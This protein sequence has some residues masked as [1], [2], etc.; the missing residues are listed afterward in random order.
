MRISFAAG[1]RQDI[2]ESFQFY[3]RSSPAAAERFASAINT[4]ID[5]IARDPQRFLLIRQG[6]RACSLV[7]FPFQVVYRQN[8]QENDLLILAIAHAKR[9][10]GFWRDRG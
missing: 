5:S 4:A 2:T 3:R 1:A 9:Q 10:P 7:G 6:V 8:S